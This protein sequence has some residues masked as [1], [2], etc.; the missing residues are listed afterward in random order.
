MRQLFKRSGVAG[1]PTA[2]GRVLGAVTIAVAGI[3]MMSAVAAWPQSIARPVATVRLHKP[4]IIS[5]PQ[6]TAH[7]GMVAR[8]SRLDA[9]DLD[10]CRAVLDA[11]IDEHLIEQ[12]AAQ[13]RLIPTEAEVDQVLVE[14]RRQVEQQLGLEQ[15]YTDAAWAAEIQRQSGLTPDEYRERM[16]VLIATERLVVEMRPGRLEEVQLPSEA[17]V[18]EFYDMNIPQFAQPKMALVLHIHF[19][20]QGL[21]EDAVTRAR[22]RADQALQ[23]LRD[24]AGFDDLVVKYSDDGNSRFNG[25]ELGNRYLRR[26]DARGMETLGAEFLRTV[27]AMQV[28]ETSGVVRSHVGLH[29]LKIADLLPARILTL[30]DQVT[31]R[32]S[33]TVRGQIT[34]LLATDRQANTSQQ[35]VQEVIAELRDRAAVEIFTDNLNATCPTETS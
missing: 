30:D 13:Q 14:R 34:A 2:R 7:A 31:P 4:E 10:Q 19:R 23:E 20:T 35:V 16:S 21:D 33:Q 3:A 17:E 11:L 26:D 32:S 15:P 12:E 24:G 5:S 8:Q 1:A 9:L 22:E 6:F 27:F 28:G 25:G 18:A 29:I